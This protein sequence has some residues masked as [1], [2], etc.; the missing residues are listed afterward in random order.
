M[1]KTH[2]FRIG[3]VVVA[4]IVLLGLFV[5]SA[6]ADHSWGP[7]HWG[8]IANPFT[9]KLGDNVSSA[10]DSYLVT[11]ASDWSLS[12]V[13]DTVKVYGDTN[14]KICKPASGRVQVCNSSYGRN[15]WLGV[16]SIWINSSGHITQGAV[17]LNDSYFNY[18]P[19]N[20]SAWK[21][22]VMC[23]EIGHTFGL[24]HQDENFYNLP[25]GSCMDYSNNPTPNQHPNQHDYEQLETIYNSHLDSSNT[26]SQLSFSNLGKLVRAGINE[27]NA[28]DD[29]E[30]G[31]EIR[32]SR[33]NRHSVYEKKLD[34]GE[35]VYTFV[36]WTDESHK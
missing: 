17:K 30:W 23:Q 6:L 27:V 20:T 29:E 34:T 5:V 31:K 11:S 36:I 25:L 32:K 1:N 14:P 28:Q 19:Y 4:V 10:W 21:N 24:D 33:D 7:Y 22:L 18:A 2:M 35:K 12:T 16:A 15:G 26:A 8:R 3:L 13:L 9:L